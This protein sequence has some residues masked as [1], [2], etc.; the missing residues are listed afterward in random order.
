MLSMGVAFCRKNG[1]IAKN[2]RAGKKCIGIASPGKSSG[3]STSNGRLMVMA[4]I[5]LAKD[6][7]EMAML[8][9]PVIFSF[10]NLNKRKYPRDMSTQPIMDEPKMEPALI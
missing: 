1:S 3:L 6:N 8:R 7:T 9:T 2:A 10:L 5:I 4:P